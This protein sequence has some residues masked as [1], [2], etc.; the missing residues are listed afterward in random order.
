MPRGD[1]VEN[2]ES[3][4]EWRCVDS[5]VIR[6]FLLQSEVH[7]C[8]ENGCKNHHNGKGC[9]KGNNGGGHD[10]IGCAFSDAG[11]DE[12]VMQAGPPKPG[13]CKDYGRSHQPVAATEVK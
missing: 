11:S 9:S 5:T 13:C 7:R 6:A 4:S 1:K 8:N 10:R 2:P 3:R 12:R